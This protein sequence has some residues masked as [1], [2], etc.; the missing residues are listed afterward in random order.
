LK[1]KIAAIKK[2]LA[3]AK[4]PEN[5]KALASQLKAVKKVEA[6]RKALKKAPLAKKRAI[7]ANK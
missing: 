4:S 7:L 3:K 1:A 2:A 5:K 6:L